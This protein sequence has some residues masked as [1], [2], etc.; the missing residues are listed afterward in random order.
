MPELL[1]EVG[2]EELPAGS[3]RRA[4]D[5]LAFEILTRLT[6]ASVSHGAH[7]TLGTPRRLIVSIQDVL[8]RQPDVPTASRGPAVKAAFDAEGKPSKA[9][10]GFC[11]GQGITPDQV[12]VEGD[13][14]WAHRVVPGKPTRELLAEILPEAIRSLT[15]D[16]TMRW[17]SGRFR[18]ARPIRWILA[19]F[20]S[21]V[22]PF[23]LEGILSGDLSYGH[24]FRSPGSFSAANG[25]AGLLAELRH[26]HVEP[27]AEKRKAAIRAGAEAH[28]ADTSATSA[29][30]IEENAYLTE[31]PRCLLGNFAQEF[32]ELPD[33]VLI[34]VMAKHERF[35]P[36]RN[37]QGSLTTGFVSVCNGGDEN[38]VREGNEW[39][40]NAR[41][42]DARHFFLEDK[43]HTLSEFLERTRS[44]TFQEKLGSVRDRADRLAKLAADIAAWSGGSL[45]DQDYAR[46]AGLYA[47]AD[48]STGLVSE[49]DELQ[50]VIGG[51]YGSREDFPPPVTSAISRQYASFSATEDAV[52]DR[53]AFCLV[54]ADQI[55]KLAGYLGIGA[56]PT[57]SSDPYGLRR[58]ATTIIEACWAWPEAQDLTP[59]LDSAFKN[60]ADG[61][62]SLDAD[63]AT[64]HLHEIFV[65][66]YEGL[67]ASHRYDLVQAALSGGMPLLNPRAVQFRI[68]VM[69]TISPETAFIQTA[70]RPLNITAAAEKKGLV[71]E[72]GLPK[73]EALQSSEASALLRAVETARQQVRSAAERA[74]VAELVT[75]LRTLAK[76]IDSF[77]DSTMV[78][79][80]DEL[81]RNA[82]LRLLA[83]VNGLL[84]Q[85]GDFTKIVIEG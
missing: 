8:D 3:I 71:I 82:R 57:G 61:Q 37:Q 12:Q 18:F 21:E 53:T 25:L 7:E 75:G 84:L 43:K 32:L 70:T 55:D 72:P 2:C 45:S 14:V 44:M 69:E 9:L 6:A 51:I 22:V 31:Q 24:R 39:V 48:L 62:V 19:T 56:V 11:R 26:R 41:L 67:L 1:L 50:G 74:D 65:S 42:N 47:K 76:P 83:E 77:F 73:D 85:A 40:V 79:A 29:A 16:K 4:H 78:M 27:D 66:R 10:E 28:S 23:E 35:F 49:L 68:Q 81:V 5:Q 33:P 60:Y 80:D 38:T 46:R 63:K 17:G 58:A 52:A 59:L 34:T 54:L 64:Q 30:L 36:V 15:F 13:Y 20:G